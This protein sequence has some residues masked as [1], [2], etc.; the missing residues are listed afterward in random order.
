TYPLPES[1]LDR[2]LLRI[3]VGYP[4]RE[5]EMQVLVSRR[6][7]EPVD[8]LEPIVSCQQIVAMQE[9]VREVNVDE[10]MRHYLLDLV[11]ATRNCDQ[12]HVGAST[13][14]ALCL[15]RA[16][17]AL[18]FVEGREFVVPDDIKRLAVPVLSHRVITRGFVH[19]GNRAVTE[20]IID[21][22][23]ETVPVPT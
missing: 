12:L 17:Q 6:D 4:S 2:F 19:S 16:A 3:A 5:D 1:Q 21:R 7:G 18:A 11:E 8:Q 10:A 23:A 13:R 15:Y 20:Q 14:G 22:L 9:Q